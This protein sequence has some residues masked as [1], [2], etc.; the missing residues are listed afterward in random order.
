MSNKISVVIPLFNKAKHIK[1]TLNSVLAQTCTDFEIIVVN[2]GST[3]SSA[4]ILSSIEAKRITVF[5][6]ENSGVA[7]ARNFGV[8]KAKNPY[9][10]FLDAD[11]YWYPNHLENLN[12]LITKFPNNA[13]Y[14]SAYE[15]EHNK[16][17]TLPINTPLTHLGD[18]W[19]GV[20]DDFFANSMRDCL[21]WTSAICVNKQDFINIGKFNIN[22]KNGQ[23]IDLWIR[24][25]LKHKLVFS[26]KTTACYMLD[27]DNSISQ[28]DILS[29]TVIDFDIFQKENPVNISLISYL[30]FNRYSIALKY[31]VSGEKDLFR[32]YKS[33][34]DFKN[35][36]CRQRIILASPI[37]IL[38]ALRK[39]KAVAE[40]IGVRVRSS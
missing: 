27:V 40:N 14:A 23:D 32:V 11:D 31:K 3:D 16:N 33:K 8:E 24:L 17:L 9:I 30:D 6:I 36:T 22:Y 4:S 38:K 37:C 1:A 2:D 18:E 34:I 13:W 5:L 25:A 7:N 15:I 12:H 19:Y 20:I 39:C 29:K 10:A 21:A 28:K 35:L 26:N